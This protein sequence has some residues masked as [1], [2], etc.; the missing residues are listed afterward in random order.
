[1]KPWNL[2]GLTNTTGFRALGTISKLYRLKPTSV[3]TRSKCCDCWSE[4]FLSPTWFII[5]DILKWFGSILIW[6]FGWV[7]KNRWTVCVWSWFVKEAVS[8][9]TL[10]LFISILGI[11]LFVNKVESCCFCVFFIVWQCGR[12][13]YYTF[14]YII[15]R[16]G[17][18]VECNSCFVRGRTV[19]SWRTWRDDFWLDDL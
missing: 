7:V 13:F 17:R 14:L 10:T 1:M 6:V 5:S 16:R 8:A 18:C 9:K 19:F 3:W 12:R 4:I 11:S 15:V 2:T